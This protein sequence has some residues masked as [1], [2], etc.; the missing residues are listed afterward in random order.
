MKYTNWDSSNGNGAAQTGYYETG[1]RGETG[2]GGGGYDRGKE[3]REAIAVGEN[4]LDSLRKAYDELGSARGW[5]LLDLFGG[6]LISSLIKHFKIDDAQRYLEDAKYWLEAFQDELGDIRDLRYM[7]ISVDGFLTFADF[8]FD[9]F[10]AD[11]LVQSRIAEAR[12][13]LEDAIVRVEGILNRL[14]REVE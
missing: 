3:I 12:T 8:F 6:G 7:D 14:Y 10:L 4:A 2:S 11:I 5:G 9:G 13:T 1:F